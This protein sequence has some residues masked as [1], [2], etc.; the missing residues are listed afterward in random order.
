MEKKKQP[1][2]KKLPA[3]KKVIQPGVEAAAPAASVVVEEA[4]V[5]FPVVGIG[6]SA[7]GLAAF[8]KFFAGMPAKSDSGMAFVLVQH[9][10]PDHKSILSDLVKRYTRMKVFEVK[11]G[12]RVQPDCAYIIPPNRDMAFLHGSLYL[13]EPLA[14]RGLRL[15]IDFFFRSLAQDQHE[16]A[17][18]IVLSGT[19]SDGTLGLRAVKGEG[20]MAMAQTPESTE[21]D[22]M[23]VSAISTGLV[24]F[25][26]PPGE[27]PAQ[28]IAF[29]K[30]VFGRKP[31]QIAP[32]AIKAGDLLKKIYILLRAN[33]GHDF[34]FYKQNTIVRRI[35]RRMAVNQ[36]ERMEDYLRYLQQSPKEVEALFRDLLIGVTSFFRDPD[37]FKILTETVVPRLF[38]KLPR[39]GVIRVW[40]PGC[41]TGEEAYSIAILLQEYMQAH[42]QIYKVQIFA[43]D[44]DKQAIITARNG[45]YPVSIIADVSTE[46]LSRFFTMSDDGGTY[47]VQKFIRDMLIFSEQ[48]VIL[49]PPFSR[50]G[51][52]S[53]R[54]LLIYMGVELQKKVLSLFH[55]ALTQEGFLF[56]GSAESIGELTDAFNVMD[57]KWKLYQ[58]KGMA[59]LPPA[60]GVRTSLLTAGDLPQ[61][62]AAQKPRGPGIR[63]VTEH[64][65]LQ[66]YSPAGVVINERGE[67]LYIHGSTGQFLEPASGE[68]SVNI[69]RMAR[70]G[71]K[72]ELTTAIRRVSAGKEPAYY[73]GLR[74]KSRDKTIVVN[75]T[76]RPFQDDPNLPQG[77]MLV[78][79]EEV[80]K[81]DEPSAG[82]MPLPPDGDDKIKT[83]ERELQD[84]E[85]Y[86][87][88]TFEELET[89]NEEL[90]STNEELQ[91]ANEELGSTNEELETSREELQSLNEELS[92]VNSELQGKV[93]Q[94]SQSGNYMHNLLAATGVGTIFVD[95][96]MCITFYTPA[97]AL[98]VHLIQGDIGRPIGHV[99]TN[100]VG[101][102]RLAE[103]IKAVLDRLTPFEAEVLSRESLW[104]LMRILPFRTLE[105]TISGAVIT[106][107]D[108]TERK[109]VEGELSEANLLRRMAVV[110]RDSDDAITVQD[111]QGRILAWN[112]GAS[113]MYGWSESEA[114]A[115][116]MRKRI[117]EGKAE[118]EL[119]MLKKIALGNIIEPF[120]T[121]RL[122]KD[123]EVVDVW[124]TASALI[125]EAGKLYA[126]STTE[127][128]IG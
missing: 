10:A 47:H 79:F 28:L 20:G 107:I 23:P 40:V 29:A 122:A 74:V 70:E 34:S 14:P 45:K 25:V 105:N 84:K 31:R 90:K 97:A 37:A 63:E 65:L 75:L 71:L 4:Q 98:S 116:N 126:I 73:P 3:R 38:D 33:T 51:L 87:Q 60:L 39:G 50:L 80:R 22:G 93:D 109:R 76:V 82:V 96:N 56:L 18:C 115:M 86:L 124:L 15:P 112:P 95:N 30:Q 7:G 118:N 113:R 57:R 46:R 59:Y 119:A 44:I 127:R 78:T 32:Q 83:L 41:S 66:Q 94:L 110:V 2:K 49:D 125:N 12:I 13:S 81:Q 17:I 11:D 92:T 69:V 123:S 36:V 35:E 111:L 61:Y 88:T 64:T 5:G 8:E 16:R 117:P 91:S 104:Y 108:I 89:S 62:V 58:H 101:Y 54:N 72:R 1:L 43:T 102:D 120:K 114:L 52:I 103:D 9:L 53:C 26:L 85:E 27:M 67:A 121:Q 99:V 6:A 100:L 21:Y 106:F 128:K 77:L 68:A 24:D 55:Y 19:G 48:D 42:K